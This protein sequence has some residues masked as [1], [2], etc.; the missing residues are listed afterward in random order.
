MFFHKTAIAS[1]VFILCSMTS[2]QAAT[3]WEGGDLTVTDSQEYNNISI[4]KNQLNN[5]GNLT[6]NEISV[7]GGVRK[8]RN[9]YCKYYFN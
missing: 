8:Y 6:A 9:N 1:A 4:G 5:S 3:N 2:A 7:M